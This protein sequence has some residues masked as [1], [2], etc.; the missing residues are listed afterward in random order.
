MNAGIL[1][2]FGKIASNIPHK[3]LSNA[4]TMHGTTR[5]PIL[6]ALSCGAMR[7]ERE[8]THWRHCRR[9]RRRHSHHH[10]VYVVVVIIVPSHT[11]TTRVVGVSSSKNGS[12]ALQL[13]TPP[14]S[15][16]RNLRRLA[17]DHHRYP[18]PPTATIHNLVCQ[19]KN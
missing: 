3:I 17:L 10:R 6:H 12:S 16:P 14:D 4:R 7:T 5:N 9:L 11:T 2:I 13:V 15:Q 8:V 1:H 18:Y 19:G